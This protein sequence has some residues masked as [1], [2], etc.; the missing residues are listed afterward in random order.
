MDRFI[1]KKYLPEQK[2]AFFCCIIIY[3]ENLSP[4]GREPGETTEQQSRKKEAQNGK[5]I[6]TA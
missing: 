2:M 5:S 1:F 3:V 4:G 6:R